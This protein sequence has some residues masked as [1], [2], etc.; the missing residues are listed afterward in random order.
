MAVLIPSHGT[1]PVTVA[2]AAGPGDEATAGPGGGG[3]ALVV[4]SVTLAAGPG[5]LQVSDDGRLPARGPAPAGP[6]PGAGDRRGRPD[7]N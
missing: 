6:G 5:R 2:R 1:V 4:H 3:R 7:F